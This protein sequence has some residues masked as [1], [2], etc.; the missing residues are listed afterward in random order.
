MQKTIHRRIFALI[1]LLL[2]LPILLLP[3]SGIERDESFYED[4]YYDPEDDYY[5]P[6]Y[7]YGEDSDGAMLLLFWL[8]YIFYGFLMPAPFLVLGL[9]FP[10][11]HGLGK[12]KHW[13]ATAISAGAWMLLAF[14]LAVVLVL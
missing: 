3:A 1:A 10:H 8:N 14:L 7:E 5:D 13:Y 12:P 9:I 2:L 6:E 11:V 4:D